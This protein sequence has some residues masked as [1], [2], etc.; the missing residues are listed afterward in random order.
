MLDFIGMIITAALMML[1]VNALTTFM[2][3]AFREG[4]TGGR[5]WRLDRPCCRGSDSRSRGQSRSSAF[6]LWC[7]FSRRRL[8]PHG[9]RRARRC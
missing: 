8:Q 1:V 7:H 3:L 6:S 2:D 9:R 5:D 4:Y